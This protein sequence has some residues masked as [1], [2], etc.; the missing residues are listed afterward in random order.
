MPAPKKPSDATRA[1]TFQKLRADH[2]K[3][4]ASL[5]S[6]PKTRDLFA[7]VVIFATTALCEAARKLDG[8]LFA[9]GKQPGLPLRACDKPVCTCRMGAKRRP[10]QAKRSG[11][12]ARLFGR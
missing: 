4:L 3:Q 7:G 8:Q 1:K 5:F 2:Q 11:F 12:F 9:W 10:A 6:D